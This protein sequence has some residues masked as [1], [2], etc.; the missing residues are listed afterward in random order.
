[1][2]RHGIVHRD[3]KLEN[4]L[5]QTPGDTTAI[6]LIDFGL[7]KHFVQDQHMQQAVGST[8]YVAPG[9]LFARIS[10]TL[11]RATLANSSQHE[12]VVSSTHPSPLSMLHFGVA[13][14]PYIEHTV[15]S[16]SIRW[17]G[18]FAQECWQEMTTVLDFQSRT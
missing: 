5:M 17:G 6:K 11:T 1:M 3:L 7:S 12:F 18:V 10:A 15:Y 4:W 8:Y 14:I 13:A 16:I 2:H 9:T